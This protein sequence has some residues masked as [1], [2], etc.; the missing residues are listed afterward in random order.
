MDE[1]EAEAKTVLDQW[2][3]SYASLEVK[4]ADLTQKLERWQ[5]TAEK[6]DQEIEML[7][8]A[9][10]VLES[11]LADLDATARSTKQSENVIAEL[12][13]TVS[14]DKEVVADLQSKLTYPWRFLVIPC[15]Y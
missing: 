5:E 8:G 12:E 4:C 6:K 13:R 1:Q 2:Q 15:V 11:Q 14:E 7:N 10:S 9:N 3:E